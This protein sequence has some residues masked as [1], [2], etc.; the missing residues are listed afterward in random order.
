MFFSF[1]EPAILEYP[2]A[3]GVKL[4]VS[5]INHASARVYFT[6]GEDAPIPIPDG[7]RILDNSNGGIN[8]FP[9]R[10]HD[11]FV[12]GAGDSYTFMLGGD[13]VMK[14][15]AQRQWCIRKLI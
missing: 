6:D 2:L 5:R 15:E 14:L 8:V 7:F 10:E 1:H 3:L 11:E 12:L 13:V 9:L 4:C